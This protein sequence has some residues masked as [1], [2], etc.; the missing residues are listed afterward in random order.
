[1]DASLALNLHVGDMVSFKC[2]RPT[3]NLGKAI[4][5]L[6]D[7]DD[8]YSFF[9]YQKW[10]RSREHLELKLVLNFNEDGWQDEYSTL[11]DHGYLF[12]FNP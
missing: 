7:E 10:Y 3:G 9:L 8:L 2:L 5:A 4:L 1:M 11:K 12:C 6:F